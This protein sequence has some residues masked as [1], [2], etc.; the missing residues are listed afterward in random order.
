MSLNRLRKQSVQGSES[1]GVTDYSPESLIS[2]ALDPDD[3][4]QQDTHDP[5]DIPRLRDH[6]I[7]ISIKMHFQDPV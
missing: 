1:H 3:V 5:E 7:R 2:S 4:D 6:V